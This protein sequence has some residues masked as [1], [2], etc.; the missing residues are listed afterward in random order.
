M[1]YVSG[2]FWGNNNQLFMAWP[3]DTILSEG[4]EI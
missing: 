1:I 2:G 4:V 3:V